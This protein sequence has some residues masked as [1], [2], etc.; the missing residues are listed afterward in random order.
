MSDDP[1]TECPECKGIVV[2]LISVGMCDIKY[3]AR[4]LYEKVIK[5]EAKEIADKI[6]NGD[7]DAAAD[8]F[9]EPK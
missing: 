6:R 5:P 7:E 4:D 3:D 1:L 2:R 9:G 8:I